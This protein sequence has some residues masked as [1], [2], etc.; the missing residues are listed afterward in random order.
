MV[1]DWIEATQVP[2]MQVVGMLMGFVVVEQMYMRADGVEEDGE[3]ARVGEEAIT[4]GEGAKL[5]QSRGGRLDAHAV[6]A[7]PHPQGKLFPLRSL[8]ARLELWGMQGKDRTR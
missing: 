6:G 5:R 1:T 4:A 2:L 3:E 8:K 7:T